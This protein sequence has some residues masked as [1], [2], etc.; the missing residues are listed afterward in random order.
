LSGRG[1]GLAFGSAFDATQ[2]VFTKNNK[3]DYKSAN[4][5]TEQT[6]L[7]YNKQKY[8]NPQNVATCVFAYTGATREFSQNIVKH[9]EISF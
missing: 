5:K 2:N 8:D 7:E 9:D 6:T 4:I 3:E 1:R